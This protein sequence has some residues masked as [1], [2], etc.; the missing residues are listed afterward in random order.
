LLKVATLIG[1]RL[2]L[3]RRGISLRDRHS[4]AHHHR[5]VFTLINEPFSLQLDVRRI[6]GVALDTIDLREHQG[7]HPRLGVVDVVPYVALAVDQFALAVSL[8]DETAHWMA[9]ELSIPVFLYGPL[10]NGST[11]SLPELRRTAYR[12]LAPDLGPTTL[13]PRV[14]AS[15]LGARPVLVAWNLWLDGVDLATAKSIAKAVRSPSVRALGIDVAPLV[16]VSCNVIDVA[17]TRPSEIYDRVSELL[18]RSGAIR[19]AELVGLAPRTLLEQ[20]DPKRWSEL[21]LS[22]DKTIE[23]SLGR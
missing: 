19:R 12:E 4:D 21:G 17:A 5:S 7:V 15:A 9:N 18:P 1:S 8:R 20:E 16:Q 23:A 10:A 13:D 14:G 2:L 22:P 3:W 11:R 6:V